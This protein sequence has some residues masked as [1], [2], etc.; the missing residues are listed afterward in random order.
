VTF[1]KHR[2]NAYQL[3]VRN[4]CQ[5]LREYCQRRGVR[6]FQASTDMPLEDL[7]LKQLRAAEVWG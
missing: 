7:L 4:F 5:R 2:L 6:F 1:M 3:T